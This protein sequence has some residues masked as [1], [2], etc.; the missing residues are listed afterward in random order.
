MQSKHYWNNWHWLPNLIESFNQSCLRLRWRMSFFYLSGIRKKTEFVLAV[1]SGP[2]YVE[3]TYKYWRQKILNCYPFKALPAN[4][5]T[6]TFYSI[7]LSPTA[8]LKPPH[9]STP[10]LY[11]PLPLYCP[12]RPPTP[13]RVSMALNGPLRPLRPST[14]LRPSISVCPLPILQPSFP[15]SAP[16]TVLPPP[17]LWPS[18]FSTVLCPLYQTRFCIIVLRNGEVV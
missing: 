12:L 5:S 15:Y 11:G 14:S 4:I 6:L 17:P 18:V 2:I 10:H 8:P 1:R 3:L 9:P 7:P 13:L 16:S